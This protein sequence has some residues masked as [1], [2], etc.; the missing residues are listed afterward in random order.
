MGVHSAPC[1]HCELCRKE[2]WQLC[3][4][5]MKEKVL[6]AFAQYLL[7]PAS[8][9]KQNLF[10]RPASVTPEH[11]ALL[12]PVACVVHGLQAI[13]WRHVESVLVLGLGAMGLFF[14]QLL[15]HYT[16]AHRAGAW[17]TSG[18]RRTRPLFRARS[19]LGSDT[20]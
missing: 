19:D 11:A 17:E 3:P 14:A 9:A 2:R 6:G 20:G 7:V 1:L 8:V 15:P 16:R 4:D 5:V 12:E 13:D 10:T 18:A